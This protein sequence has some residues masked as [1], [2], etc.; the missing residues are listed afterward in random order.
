MPIRIIAFI[1][2]IAFICAAEV[3]PDHSRPCFPGAIYRKAVSS[4]DAW[5]G[6]D[7]V[8][9]LPAFVPDDARRRPSGRP[10][11]NASVY[12]GGRASDTEIDAGVLWE[13]IR[14]PDGTVSKVGKA[15]RPFWRNKKW[16]NAPAEEQYYYYPG[17]T[18]R[19]RVWTDAADKLK[20][21]IDLLARRGD[22]IDHR[23]PPISTLSVDFDAP[24]FGP[25]RRQ[26]F[27]R[28]T[29]I[30]QAGNEGKPAQ[31]TTARVEACVFCSVY[32]LRGQERLP[33]TAERFTDMRC[34]DRRFFAVDEPTDEGGERITI[35]GSR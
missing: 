24:G 33:M 20:M 25:G 26:E 13:V 22:Q 2:A 17:D 11:D 27:K 34:P 8:V 19:M 7:A 35:D 21:Q 9:T 28:V 18:I 16:F 29:A 1:T 15:F 30:D 10:A 32:L 12:L 6:I 23:R 4:V 3:P 14:Q 31:P 5:T